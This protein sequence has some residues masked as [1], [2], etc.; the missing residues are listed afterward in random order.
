MNFGDCIPQTKFDEA[1][2]ARADAIGFPALN[3]ILPALLDWLQDM[4]WP[5]ARATRNLLEKA[6]PEIIPHIRAILAGDDDVWKYWIVS[7]LVAHLSPQIQTAL[8]ADIRRITETPTP[9]EAAEEVDDVA[10][11]VLDAGKS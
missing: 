2:I 4:N 3:P 9:G 8:T 1:A 6:G 11:E 7:A 5:V 10:R